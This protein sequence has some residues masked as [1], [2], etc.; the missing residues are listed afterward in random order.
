MIFQPYQSSKDRTCSLEQH[1]LVNE[2]FKR[3]VNAGKS[4]INFTFIRYLLPGNII[5]KDSLT[6]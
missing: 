2:N 3:A 1:L 6:Q 4:E 5:Q